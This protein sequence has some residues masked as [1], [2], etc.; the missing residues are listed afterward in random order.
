MDNA[1]Y[2]KSERESRTCC[3][4][5]ICDH[6]LENVKKTSVL[7]GRC[8]QVVL[9]GLAVTRRAECLTYVYIYNLFDRKIYMIEKDL[10][11]ACRS[12]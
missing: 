6:S 4:C 1:N 12:V 2:V 8:N 9:E 3:R 10:A 7:A 11:K 5:S